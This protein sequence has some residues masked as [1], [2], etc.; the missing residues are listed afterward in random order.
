MTSVDEKLKLAQDVI[1]GKI[2]IFD[3]RFKKIYPFTTE[4]ISGYMPRFK[5]KGTKLLT[6]GSSIDQTIN[7]SLHGCRDITILDICPYAKDHFYL[8]DAAIQTLPKHDFEKFLLYKGYY[9]G[10]FENGQVLNRDTLKEISAALKE[11]DIDSHQFWTRLLSKERPEL[12]RKRLFSTDERNSHIIKRVNDYL[13]DEDSYQKARLA[14][15]ETKMTF[16]EG[17]IMSTS[18]P[19]TFDNIFLSNIPCNYSLD[20][21]KKLV[22]RL[23]PHLNDDGKILISYLYSLTPDFEFC[24]GEPEIYDVMRAQ[25]LLPKPNK[26]EIFESINGSYM[27]DGV[28]VY[29]K[30]K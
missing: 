1:K 15:Q 27:T 9:F 22:E 25:E 7:A 5:L 28:L 12:V 11:L 16:I 14:L 30:K 2:N 3:D 29:Q 20:E 6:V 19:G 23:I 18:I 24:E 13:H 10:L 26:L 8:K 17:D 21:T 4:N